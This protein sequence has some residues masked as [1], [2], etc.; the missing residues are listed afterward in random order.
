MLQNLASARHLPFFDRAGIADHFHCGAWQHD[1]F[2]DFAKRIESKS[3]PFPCHFGAA[4]FRK[5]ELRYFFSERWDDSS[6]ADALD[7]YVRNSRSFGQNTSFVVMI[8]TEG[9]SS[10]QEYHLLFWRV[11]E[12]INK[13][14]K[15]PWPAHIPDDHEDSAWE[16][17]FADEALFVVCTTPAHTQRQSRYS[18]CFTLLFQ[19]RW[20]FANILD[21][22]A[23]AE[24]AFNSV[25]VLLKD[26]DDAALSPYLGMYGNPDNREHLQYFLSDDESPLGCPFHLGKKA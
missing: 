14:D 22:P 5:D 15:L 4:G 1:A 25:R 13:R 12:G 20:V 10:I 17:C 21:T 19:P 18:S 6:I 2:L 23:K 8:K 26:Y 11:L 16:F 3:S 9:V 7:H 24:K